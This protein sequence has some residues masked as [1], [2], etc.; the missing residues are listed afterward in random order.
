MSEDRTPVDKAPKIG[1]PE[2]GVPEI[3]KTE[4]SA[5]GA[6]TP[7]A[8]QTPVI[9]PGVI[10]SSVGDAPSPATLNLVRVAVALAILALGIVAMKKLES[11]KKGPDTTKPGEM[12]A[13]AAGIRVNSENVRT[14]LTGYGSVR[15]QRKVRLSAEVTGRIVEMHPQLKAGDLVAAGELIFAIDSRNY[16][17]RL[18]DAVSEIDRLKAEQ[19]R[20]NLQEANSKRLL[21]I[22]RGSLALAESDFERMKKLAQNSGVE[23]RARVEAS[24]LAFNREKVQVAN[25]ESALDLFPVQRQ[26]TEIQLQKA[27]VKKNEAELNLERTRILAPF[28][29]RVIDRSGELDQVVTPGQ[30]LIT[31]ADDS[32]LELAVPLFSTDAAR[33]LDVVPGASAAAWFEKF[34]NRDVTV[35]WK[36]EEAPGEYIWQGRLARVEQY[37]A[38][39]RMLTVVVEVGAD[40]ESAPPPN[41]SEFPLIEGM[42]CKVDI[43]GSMADNVFRVPS[44][45]VSKDGIYDIVLLGNGGRRENPDQHPNGD[46]KR[47]NETPRSNRILHSVTCI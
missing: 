38:E 29:G 28:A 2:I 32:T 35:R 43:P 5:P 18:D 36:W 10:T 3:R 39:S 8:R 34:A 22:A 6:G 13:R 30:P 37:N 25:L 24:E 42:F 21:E 1:A 27:Q 41:G 4:L 26:Q 40:E 31:L 20:L 19:E 7:P 33:F 16:Q 14:L 12:V 23:T 45:A 47:R 15:P 46:P 9:T 11:L 17:L 44:G